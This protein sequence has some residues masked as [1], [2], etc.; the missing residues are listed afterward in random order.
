MKST[1]LVNVELH[2]DE[3]WGSAKF[4]YHEFCNAVVC[5]FKWI[6]DGA[7]LFGDTSGLI[8]NFHVEN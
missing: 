2:F 1:G 8:R 6:L 3:N 7:F 4:K 5:T